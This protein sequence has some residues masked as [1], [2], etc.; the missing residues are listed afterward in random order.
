MHH[1]VRGSGS[2]SATA[3]AIAVIVAL[4]ACQSRPETAP[5]NSTS[6]A[7]TPASA[8]V[9]GSLSGPDPGALPADAEEVLVGEVGLA[10]TGSGGVEGTI[11]TTSVTCDGGY[12]KLVTSE[13]T[14]MMGIVSI[15]DWNCGKALEQWNAVSRPDAAVGIRYNADG[16][17]ET[18]TLINNAGGSLTVRIQGLWRSS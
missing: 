15:G 14:Y 9:A 5:V 2:L 3:F 1:L 16:G 4:G 11:P 7:Q 18:V 10:D 6:Q 8:V 12:M 17:E 13:G